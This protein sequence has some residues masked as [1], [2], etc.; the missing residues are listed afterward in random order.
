[1]DAEADAE[2]DDDG[3]G[4]ADPVESAVANGVRSRVTGASA[5]LRSGC[6]RN[7]ALTATIRARTAII[8]TDNAREIETG[9]PAR[10]RTWR[11]ARGATRERRR[12]TGRHLRPDAVRGIRNPLVHPDVADVATRVARTPGASESCGTRNGGLRR[13]AAA[14]KTDKTHQAE[15][16]GSA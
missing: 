2:G 9:E 15:P 16:S 10:L 14:A 6:R 7:D 8:E 5:S 11:P 12:V 13:S 1:V 4:E 3:D